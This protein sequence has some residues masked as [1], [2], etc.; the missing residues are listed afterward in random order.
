MEASRGHKI[1]RAGLSRLLLAT[2]WVL[3]PEPKSSKRATSALNYRVTSP[4]LGSNLRLGKFPEPVCEILPNAPY[5]MIPLIQQFGS[6][7]KKD[8][9][10]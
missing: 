8:I 1:T 10:M 7:K 9:G 2:M 5:C 3:G 4:P 6:E